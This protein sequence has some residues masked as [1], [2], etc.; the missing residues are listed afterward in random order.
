MAKIELTP[1]AICGGNEEDSSN[2][3]LLR[4]KADNTETFEGHDT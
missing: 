4:N 1:Q 3:C 2:F